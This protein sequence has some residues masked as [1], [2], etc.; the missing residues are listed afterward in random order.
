MIRMVIL[1]S[2]ENIA[3][4]TNIII[5]NK[6]VWN[7]LKKEAKENHD[8]SVSITLFRHLE[9]YKEW[10]E[11]QKELPSFEQVLESFGITKEQLLENFK[12]TDVL[13]IDK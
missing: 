7:E 11:Q 5:K 9:Y 13:S 10:E 2:N 12:T 1:D 8:Q 3:R 6:E 4:K